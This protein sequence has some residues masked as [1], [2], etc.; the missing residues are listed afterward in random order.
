MYK[1]AYRDWPWCDSRL[2]EYMDKY[3]EI[4]KTWKFDYPKPTQ[5]TKFEEWES[6]F[7]NVCEQNWE[8]RHSEWASL[9]EEYK[10]VI[11]TIKSE[12]DPSIVKGDP[13]PLAINLETWVQTEEDKMY[14][15]L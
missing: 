15:K 8:W 11:E 12:G 2:E 6:I 1:Y 10:D 9:S 3:T 7:N 5:D 4:Y 13:Y 14:G